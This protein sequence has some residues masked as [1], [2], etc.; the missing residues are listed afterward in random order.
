MYVKYLAH[1][2]AYWKLTLNGSYWHHQNLQ[3]VPLPTNSTLNLSILYLKEACG[4]GALMFHQF[5]LQISIPTKV[6]IFLLPQ[7][8]VYFSSLRPSFITILSLE[9]LFLPLTSPDKANLSVHIPSCPESMTQ[10]FPL[11]FIST[12]V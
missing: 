8:Q 4:Y 2:Q 5:N 3:C 1:C 6:N 9:H 11:W 10:P 12:F 7:S